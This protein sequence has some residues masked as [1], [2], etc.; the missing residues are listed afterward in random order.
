MTTMTLAWKHGIFEARRIAANGEQIILTLV[1]PLAIALFASRFTHLAAGTIDDREHI[2]APGAIGVAIAAAA[3]SSQA[4]HTAF[5]RKYGSMRL[6]GTTP[7]GG[8]GL[9]LGKAFAVGHIVVAQ[10]AVL[11]TASALKGWR[12]AV[13]GIPFA[14]VAAIL[15]ILCFVSLALILAGTIRAEWTLGIA[16]LAWI[17]MVGV[18]GLLVPLAYR[19]PVSAEFMGY[20]PWG[21]MGESLRASLGDTGFPGT[22]LLVLACW[23]V[24]LTAIAA[25]VFRW[26]S[27]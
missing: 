10:I 17:G 7:L 22:S 5:E 23:T 26:S 6:L 11:A 19:I 9:V 20:F 18:G 8:R 13:S 15:G 12:P 25:R 24:V 3:F 16:N 4:I 1:F 27:R 2:A 14:L 21:A